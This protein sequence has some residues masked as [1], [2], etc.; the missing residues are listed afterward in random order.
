M[1]FRS[2]SFFSQFKNENTFAKTD[3]ERSCNIPIHLQ[4][5]YFP[6]SD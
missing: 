5:I 2:S 4:S 1:P 3:G 6:L